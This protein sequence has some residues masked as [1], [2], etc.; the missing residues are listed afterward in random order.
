MF[1]IRD[2]IKEFVKENKDNMKPHVILNL[3]K[4]TIIEMLSYDLQKAYILNYINKELN[5]NINYQ[6]F[7]S[8]IK[9]LKQTHNIHIKNTNKT[10]KSNTKNIK[11]D[12]QEKSIPK[13]LGII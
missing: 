1:K 2:E 6:T 9:K 13:I 4:D 8:Y 3:V 7:N 10:L 12:S 11:S 5:T